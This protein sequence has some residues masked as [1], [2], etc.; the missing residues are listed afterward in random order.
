MYVAKWDILEDV[1]AGDNAINV[2]SNNAVDIRRRLSEV[3]GINCQWD[4]GLM[5]HFANKSTKL[6]E[7]LCQADI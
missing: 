5:F 6:S 7:N 1:T 2:R 4:W 3:Y